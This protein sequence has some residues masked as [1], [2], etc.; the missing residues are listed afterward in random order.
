M[1]LEFSKDF[2]SMADAAERVRKL[3]VPLVEEQSKKFDSLLCDHMNLGGWYLTRE[4]KRAIRHYLTNPR[5]ASRL[6]CRVA[7]VA[8]Y[9]SDA[10]AVRDDPLH[11]TARFSFGLLSTTL[12][13]FVATYK[14]RRATILI[15]LMFIKDLLK[16][17]YIRDEDFILDECFRVPYCTE[18]ET[19]RNVMTTGKGIALSCCD[20][21]SCSWFCNLYR[22]RE[23]LFGSKTTPVASA[24][25]NG[26]TVTVYD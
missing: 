2:A 5:D 13:Q 11:I 18:H 26:Y 21:E 14:Q 17:C 12:D 6:P 4:E 1:L 9:F 23:L 20:R 19:C 8:A 22:Q 10:D 7:S 24:C 25:I 3:G 15:V 16:D